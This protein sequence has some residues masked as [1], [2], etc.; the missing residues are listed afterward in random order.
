MF[1]LALLRRHWLD[2]GLRM[3]RTYRYLCA[4]FFLFLRNMAYGNIGFC[5]S[6]R[7][8]REE[9]RMAYR[10]AWRSNISM[11]QRRHQYEQSVAAGGSISGAP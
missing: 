3:R 4:L 1:Y 10:K 5:V 9:R 2:E 8:W 7:R 11:R 6:A